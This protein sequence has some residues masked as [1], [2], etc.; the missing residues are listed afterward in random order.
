MKGRESQ[1]ARRK[2]AGPQKCAAKENHDSPR[3]ES[4][5]KPRLLVDSANPDKTV[6]QLRDILAASGQFFD[7]GEP[8]CVIYDSTQGGSIAQPLTPDAIVLMTHQ[9]CRPYSV[10]AQ[11]N[12]QRS[13]IDARLPKSIAAMYLD[14]RGEWRLP[15]LKGISS[16][17]L[18][19]DDG[20]IR[21]G[22]GYDPSS[23]MWLENVPDLAALVPAR[24]TREDAAR[25]LRLIRETF[26]TFCFA[27]AETVENSNGLR[28]VNVELPP[29]KDKS[30]FL[31]VFLMAP[32]RASLK[33]APGA[34]FAAPE[35]SGAGA[36]K[37]KL[38]RCICA[39][40]YGRQP[41]AFTPGSNT[42]ELEKRLAAKLV[43]SAPTILVDN[44]NG[45][46]LK[47]A[48]L[49]SAITES[50]AEIRILGK[51]Q[52]TKLNSTALFFVTGNGLRI[53]EDLARRFIEV[54][55]D[56]GTEDPEARPFDGDIVTEVLERRADL[57][58][59]ALTIWRWG[60][61]DASLARGKPLGGFEKW[62]QWVRD[63]LRA[64]GCQDPVERISEAKASDPRRQRTSEI[65]HI[66]W[67]RHGDHPV[68][69]KELHEDVR[70]VIDPQGRGRQFLT[71]AIRN[72][73]GTRAAG[74]MLTCQRPV[75]KWGTATYS[76]RKPA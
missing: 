7:R 22:Q 75:G 54:R 10:K 15:V 21:C 23:G 61:V 45:V 6:E 66:W 17:P 12:G 31:N 34:L 42:E 44:V 41:S 74:F 46:A 28:I 63:P 19:D 59:A 69:I 43:E 47:S 65:F 29:G 30:A 71:S 48:M 33:F 57:L 5:A 32:C 64:L 49:A 8:V 38:A 62:S 70:A 51:T 76:L 40:G 4:A 73:E 53:S 18:L 55:F 67:E 37:G 58:A 14:W 68:F 35:T 39:I 56:A 36:G 72:M 16:A 1:R 52:M 26:K 50:P 2:G 60:R 27:D 11:P 3:G 9:L 24:P 20:S 25:A 13:D